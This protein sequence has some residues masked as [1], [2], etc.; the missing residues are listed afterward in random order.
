M[1]EVVDPKYCMTPEEWEKNK[2]PV[3]MEIV[4]LKVSDLHLDPENLRNHGNENIEMLK[5]SLREFGQT[6]PL[7][8]DSS[9]MVVK[10]G[11]GRL[12]AMR[13]LGW[14]EADCILVDFSQHRGMEVLDNRLNE[15]SSWK[16]QDMDR[17]LMD[18]K[19][20]EWW[21]VDASKSLQL[22]EKEKKETQKAQMKN[23]EKKSPVCPCCGKPV[24]KI[25]VISL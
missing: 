7:I 4:R 16:D 13:A 9:S 12:T 23:R 18:E 5:R 17:W 1:G 24:H 14:E 6:K 25:K 8:V 10:I 2:K 20:V 3:K 22:L 15:L 21:G 11:N 19:G